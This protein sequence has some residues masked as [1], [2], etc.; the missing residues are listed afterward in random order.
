LTPLRDARVVEP[1]STRTG[2][3]FIRVWSEAGC[4]G[5]LRATLIGTHDVAS[6]P[7]PVGSASSPA[8]ILAQVDGWLEEFKRDD[9]SP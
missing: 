5:A 7:K 6:T 9:R 3:L 2:L 8:E 4:P 1:E